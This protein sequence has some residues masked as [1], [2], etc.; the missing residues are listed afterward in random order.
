MRAELTAVPAADS[1]TAARAPRPGPAH[2][3]PGGRGPEAQAR[4]VQEPAPA[5]DQPRACLLSVASFPWT[6]LWID[7]KDTGQRTPVV[8]FP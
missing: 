1:K 8:H 6:E 7:G 5:A 4:S 2:K 3:Q